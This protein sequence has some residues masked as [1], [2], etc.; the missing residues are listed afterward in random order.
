[1]PK[2]FCVKP[3]LH[4]RCSQKLR[5][6]S[7]G[8][9]EK[10]R[11]SFNIIAEKG[12]Y[13]CSSC[14]IRVAKKNVGN[15]AEN[16]DDIL[17]NQEQIIRSQSCIIEEDSSPTAKIID[18]I[19]TSTSSMD[20]AASEASVNEI[21]LKKKM[22][23]ENMNKFIIPIIGGENIDI[24]K[25]N[26]RNYRNNILWNTFTKIEDHLKTENPSDNIICNPEIKEKASNF[27]TIIEGWKQ[28]FPFTNRKEKQQM[29]TSLPS[30]WTYKKT[31]EYFPTISR[32]F[33]TSCREI[34]NTQGSFTSDS[35]TL[36]RNKLSAEALDCV[37]NFYNS[38]DISRIWPGMKDYVSIKQNGELVQVQKRTLLST[39]NEA[40]EEFK[41]KNHDIKIGL[42]S[43][44]K[45][46]PKNIILQGASGTHNICVCIIHQNVKLMIETAKLYTI[47]TEFSD[48][49]CCIKKIICDTP[50]PACY[51][52]KCVSCHI[53]LDTFKSQLIH[54]FQQAGYDSDSDKISFKLWEATDRCTIQ[55]FEENVVDFVEYFCQKLLLLIPHDFIK[56]EQQNYLNLL[57]LR[58]QLNEYIVMADFSENYSCII[59]D[60]VQGYYYSKE[61]VTIHPFV[62]YY[63]TEDNSLEHLSLTIIS[64][65]LMHNSTSVNLFIKKLTTFM[66]EKFSRVNKIYYFTDGAPSQYKNIKNFV[67]VLHHETDFGIKCEWNFHA[68]AHGKGPCDGIGGTIKRMARKESLSRS[69]DS[70]IKTAIELFD[71]VNN[72]NI[73]GR[74]AINFKFVSNQEYE[75]HKRILLPRY[76]NSKTIK[77]TRSYHCIVPVESNLL[78]C[79]YYSNSE[80]NIIVKT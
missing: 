46:R 64:D 66:K 48:Y 28:R 69:S 20:S 51:L 78:I 42:T 34:R 72:A 77:G 7:D 41:S 52:R 49:K 76:R 65:C 40:F 55:S 17:C 68:T 45:Q 19:P 4:G 74:T 35:P 18:E 63:K 60:E 14:Y 23:I 26:S 31:C 53:G 38:D 8:V 1:M 59:Q 9:R 43:F 54:D 71:W 22:L 37:K 67:N 10:L 15:N 61:Q 11:E 56:R 12:S 25:I 29:L 80:E 47:N 44:A 62:V 58:I 70:P 57:K 6:V 16:I 32:R 73:S 36:Q 21:E 24:K 13:I 30:L 3:F 75:E 33:F 79:K 50:T 5:N 2:T 39:I 27:D